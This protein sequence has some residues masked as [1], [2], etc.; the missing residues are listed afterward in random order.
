MINKIKEGVNKKYSSD[1]W[2]MNFK[3]SQADN[4]LNLGQGSMY[5]GNPAFD[6]G[7]AI[8]RARAGKIAA[9]KA[10][11]GMKRTAKNLMKNGMSKMPTKP[12]NSKLSTYTQSAKPKRAK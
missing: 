11:R 12:V 7:L 5:T 10:K 4:A 3:N 9:N 8:G 6:A 1:I 2:D